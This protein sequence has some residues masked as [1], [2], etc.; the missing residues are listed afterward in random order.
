MPDHHVHGPAGLGAHLDENAAELAAAP[1]TRSLGH[2]ELHAG[3]AERASAR[4]PRTDPRPATA[5][6]RSAG[7]SAYCQPSDRQMAPPGGATQPRP[8]RPRPPVWC[9][10]STTAA[11]PA[12]R[13][14]R[15]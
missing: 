7:M 14:Q 15:L 13:R 4:S 3:H 12:R 1:V 6:D 9:S 5:R 8:R 2:F 11:V 10:A